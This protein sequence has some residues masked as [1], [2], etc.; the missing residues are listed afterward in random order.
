MDNVSK[1]VASPSS[2]NMCV[3]KTTEVTNQLRTESQFGQ[4][5]LV[6]LCSG[7]LGSEDYRF[8]IRIIGRVC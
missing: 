8:W 2:S 3:V 6:L 5:V 4:A 1:H 7:R